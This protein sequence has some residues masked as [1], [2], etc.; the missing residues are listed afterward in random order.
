MSSNNYEL[1]HLGIVVKDIEAASEK[2][3]SLLDFTV[4]TQ[5]ITVTTQKIRCLYLS[6]SS[7]NIRVQLIEPTNESS[8]VQNALTKG[9]GPHHL[10]LN[11]EDIDKSIKTAED[12][13]CRVV[14]P[15]FRGEGVDGNLAAFVYAPD[16]GLIEFVER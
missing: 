12:V 13:G 8:P 7:S 16:I 2:Y 5:P 6:H 3:Q 11:C 10:C 4:E 1:D 9:G 15:P 14:T